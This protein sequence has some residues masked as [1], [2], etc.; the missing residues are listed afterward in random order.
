[1]GHKKTDAAERGNDERKWRVRNR[2]L[3][4]SN[5]DFATGPIELNNVDMLRDLKIL[6]ERMFGLPHKG[7]GKG[8]CIYIAP[9]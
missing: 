3:C 7:K 6:N 2:G 5:T 1:M 9:F 8:K 4:I